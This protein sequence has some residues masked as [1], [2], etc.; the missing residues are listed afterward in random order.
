[1]IILGDFSP[2]EV[3]R[4]RNPTKLGLGYQVMGH[5]QPSF[6]LSIQTL[7]HKSP[8]LNLYK[9]DLY[10]Q[11]ISTAGS[12]HCTFPYACS[13]YHEDITC[14]T[15]PCTVRTNW[16]NVTEEVALDWCLW[17]LYSHCCMAL[18]VCC[19]GHFLPSS[20][21]LVFVKCMEGRCLVSEIDFWLKK[22]FGIQVHKFDWKL[23]HGAGNPLRSQY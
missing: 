5:L 21:I 14:D 9:V 10:V 15:F 20:W 2:Y 8:I 18:L 13:D 4:R 1:M 19:M 22:R 7:W 16:I 17:H 12:R 6:H 11:F 23:E 3:E